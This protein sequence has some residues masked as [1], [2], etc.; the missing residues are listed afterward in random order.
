MGRF[1]GH[2]REAGPSLSFFKQLMEPGGTHPFI[3][4]QLSI[5]NT[6]NGQMTQIPYSRNSWIRVIREKSGPSTKQCRI[7]ELDWTTRAG[8]AGAPR[9]TVDDDNSGAHIPWGSSSLR[10]DS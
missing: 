3:A 9:S 1:V 2:E 4:R 10:I 8:Q 6:T 7:A 5:T